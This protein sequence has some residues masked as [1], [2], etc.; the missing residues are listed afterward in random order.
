MEECEEKPIVYWAIDLGLHKEDKDIICN[1]DWITD[2]HVSAMNTL[3]TAQFPTQQGL[4]D[5]LLLA[6]HCRYESGASNFV[7]IINISRQHWVCASNVLSSPGVVE[8]FD[9]MPKY[10]FD[11]SILKKHVATILKTSFDLHHIEVQRQIGSD[12]CGLFAIA[13]AVD[14]CLGKDPHVM[15]YKQDHLRSHYIECV[16]KRLFTQFPNSDSPRKMPTT[17]ESECGRF[18]HMQDALEQAGK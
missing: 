10:S 9:S 17:Q 7:Q 5:S 1:G 11:S 3:L 6:W 13:F 14:L 4:Q 2:K 8:V 18:L 12:D 16:D 15:S